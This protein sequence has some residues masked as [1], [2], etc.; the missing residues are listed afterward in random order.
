M[1]SCWV[2]A[3]VKSP[4]EKCTYNS[5]AALTGLQPLETIICLAPPITS[6]PRTKDSPSFC[7]CAPETSSLVFAT[8]G[9]VPMEMVWTM[10]L[11][12]P[13]V[14]CSPIASRQSSW[15]LGSS[16]CGF[17]LPPQ[18]VRIYPL[19]RPIWTCL[20]ALELLLTAWRRCYHTQPVGKDQGSEKSQEVEWAGKRLS[21]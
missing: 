11:E 21:R 18:M 1:S 3:A 6:A 10:I 20:H 4:R 17:S 14:D 12:A 7:V 9:H 16:E 19:L 15:V 13:A 8:I 2:L 5:P